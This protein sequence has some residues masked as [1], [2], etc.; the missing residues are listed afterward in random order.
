MKRHDPCNRDK[1]PMIFV[2]IVT[3]ISM[4]GLTLHAIVKLSDC[5][6]NIFC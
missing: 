2:L 1:G 5:A 3:A 6:H 4:M